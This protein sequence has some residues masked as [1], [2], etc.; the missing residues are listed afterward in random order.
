MVVSR[1]TYL[2][3]QHDWRLGKQLVVIVIAAAQ[4]RTTDRKREAD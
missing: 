2:L 3:M 1:D 4:S